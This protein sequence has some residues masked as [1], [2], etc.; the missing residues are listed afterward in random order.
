M[1]LCHL[2]AC[3]LEAYFIWP[4][5]KLARTSGS[6]NGNDLVPV[7]YSQVKKPGMGKLRQ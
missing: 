2:V 3:L 5:Y 7:Q 6:F 4:E 1:L